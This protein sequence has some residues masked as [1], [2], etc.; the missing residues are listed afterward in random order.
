MDYRPE[1]NSVTAG[2]EQSMAWIDRLAWVAL[3]FTISSAAARIF[4]EG[5]IYLIGI[6]MPL[7]WVIIGLWLITFVHFFISRHIIRSC[8]DAWKHL[9]NTRR[10]A[11]F[12]K[13]VRTGG[14]I[15]KGTD[16]YRDAIV[17]KNNRLELKTGFADQATWVH[18]T[19]ILSTLLSTVDI[20]FSLSALS[21]FCFVIALILTNWKI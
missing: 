4:G 17:N 13:I 12:D 2:V 6:S 3:L 20:E 1:E 5:E 19:L 14:I 11:L 16:G 10:N 8:A 9:T 7:Q 15:T 18:F 21:Q